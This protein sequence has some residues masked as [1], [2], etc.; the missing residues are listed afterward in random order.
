MTERREDLAQMR[1]AQ[2]RTVVALYLGDPPAPGE[3]R[4]PDGLIVAENGV[5][6][7]RT[8]IALTRKE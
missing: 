5:V 1:V 7:E 8:G 6:I 2:T 4:E 3:A